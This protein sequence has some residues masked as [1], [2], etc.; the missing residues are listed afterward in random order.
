MQTTGKPRQRLILPGFSFGEK[1]PHQ[2][3]PQD[4]MADLMPPWSM[5]T[6]YYRTPTPAEIPIFFEESAVHVKVSPRFKG[7]RLSPPITHNLQ[8]EPLHGW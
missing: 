7:P 5:G 2:T 1:A 4:S 3:E 8:G 6:Y